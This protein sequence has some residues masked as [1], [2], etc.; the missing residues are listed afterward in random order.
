MS[1]VRYKSKGE[2]YKDLKVLQ[3]FVDKLLEKIKKS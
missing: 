2:I 3:K 1:E